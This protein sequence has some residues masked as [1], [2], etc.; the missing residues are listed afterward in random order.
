MHTWKISGRRIFLL[1]L[2]L[3]VFKTGAVQKDEWEQNRN[4]EEKQVFLKK[5]IRTKR[6]LEA[7]LKLEYNLEEPLFHDWNRKQ[8]K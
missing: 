1:G 8:E 5:P 3:S 4:F 2:V 6:G 7:F